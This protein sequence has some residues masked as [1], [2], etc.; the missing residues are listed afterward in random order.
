M[1]EE[2]NPVVEIAP[3]NMYIPICVA[4]AVC[5]SAIIIAVL[6]IKFFF[7]GS[8]EKIQKWYQKNIL[9]ETV[10]TAVF[11]EEESN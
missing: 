5:I 11:N 8:Y 6:I 1:A 3:K 7:A 4:Q 9:D 2:Q 10:I